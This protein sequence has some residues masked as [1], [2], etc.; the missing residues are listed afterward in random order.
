MFP[1]SR[2][3][4]LLEKQWRGLMPECGFFDIAR[5]HLITPAL[6]KR[7]MCTSYRSCFRE[8]RAANDAEAFQADK[9]CQHFSTFAESAQ[10]RVVENLGTRVDFWEQNGNNNRFHR[11]LQGF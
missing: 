5:A 10:R 9:L 1:V 7:T 2:P 8:C 11:R 6:A 4:N 3:G